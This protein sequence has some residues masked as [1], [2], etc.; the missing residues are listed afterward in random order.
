MVIQVCLT[1]EKLQLVIEA[2]TDVAEADDTLDDKVD[3]CNELSTELID[4]LYDN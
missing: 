4:I 3:A 2:L 1:Y